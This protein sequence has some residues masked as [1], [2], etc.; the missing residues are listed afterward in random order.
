MN[1]TE[2]EAN[3]TGLIE[4]LSFKL[5]TFQLVL[6]PIIICTNV[7]LNLFVGYVLLS[8]KQLR[9]V[10][11]SI[12]FGIVASNL[13]TF[14]MALLQ[15]FLIYKKSYAACQLFT[16]LF[17]K[18][19]IVLLI[20]MLLATLERFIYVGWPLFHQVHVTA[21]RVA[22][23]QICLSLG[24][25]LGLSIPFVSGMRPIRCGSSPQN[26]EMLK[27]VVGALVIMCIVAKLFLY[28][29]ATKVRNRQIIPAN[30]IKM[31]DLS[32]Q[33]PEEPSH[34]ILRVHRNGRRTRQMERDSTMT[35]AANLIPM[36]VIVSL[37]FIHLL[38]QVICRHFFH[39][40]KTSNRLDY[41]DLLLLHVPTDLLVYIF[42]S[43]EFRSAAHRI[44]R[45]PIQP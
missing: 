17:S 19:N 45:R 21:W 36:I 33:K 7:P 41:H 11:N 35:L 22:T 31:A 6:H 24:F 27:S 4:K 42:R 28:L 1:D 39:G 23:A 20:H 3:V 29:V 9:N 30:A 18:P 8:D 25:F 44:F 37:H 2:F 14:F 10:R 12:W 34:K 26:V 32:N 38:I 43:G 40:C 16:V 13:K 15:Q 5:D